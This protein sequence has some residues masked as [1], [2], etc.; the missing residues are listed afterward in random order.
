MFESA[1]NFCILDTQLGYEFCV[2]LLYVSVLVKNK[3][4]VS[5]RNMMQCFYH[6]CME[7]HHMG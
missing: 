4:G 1:N 7:L 5:N 2:R 6:D 3:Y